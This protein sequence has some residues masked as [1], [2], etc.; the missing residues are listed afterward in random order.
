MSDERT[1]QPQPATPTCPH[2]FR[3]LEMRAEM[4]AANGHVRVTL[5]CPRH[6]SF[7]R[8]WRPKFLDTA[9]AAQWAAR[10]RARQQRSRR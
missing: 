1:I 3:D 6:G 4:R 9:R 2:C 10:E 7:P 5:A 8:G